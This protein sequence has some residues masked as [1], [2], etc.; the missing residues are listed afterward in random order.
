[1]QQLFFA[2]EVRSTKEKSKPAPLW[3]RI[4]LNGT[5]ARL[6]T[7]H[8][9]APN[10]LVK[11]D[12]EWIIK[13]KKEWSFF[14]RETERIRERCQDLNLRNLTAK[15]IVSIVTGTPPDQISFTEFAREFII[16][17]KREGLS[18]SSAKSYYDALGHLERF[19]GKSQ[20]MFKDLDQ[21]TLQEWYNSLG[22]GKHT[23][24]PK[25]YP[26][27]IGKIWD[28][29]I[30][31]YASTMHLPP[32]PRTL[33]RKPRVSQSKNPTEKALTP[34]QMHDFLFCDPVCNTP[35]RA[36]SRI[37]AHATAV[38]SFCLGGVNMKDLY[39]MPA[40]ALTE[41]EQVFAGLYGDPLW[42]LGKWG[43][44]INKFA[45]YEPKKG[46]FDMVLPVYTLTYQRA[47]T[48]TKRAD[49][50]LMKVHVPLQ[51]FE[52]FQLLRK[53]A[54]DGKLFN[55]SA[56]YKDREEIA[57]YIGRSLRKIS[58]YHGL[59]TITPYVL[60]YTFASIATNYLHIPQEDLAF[61][62]NHAS[63]HRIT[64]NYIQKDYRRADKTLKDVAKFVFTYKGAGEEGEKD[65]EEYSL[66]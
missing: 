18:D 55:L 36:K 6:K 39:D 42:S 27:L 41:T 53:G 15:D 60:R 64:G 32:Y 8:F 33:L 66:L 56:H 14:L 28:S 29:A 59:P 10:D 16:Q 51:A 20:I 7:N 49:G 11:E 61:T 44:D 24:I 3:I 63:A 1:M 25:L 46:S 47:K 38:L 9:I 43:I 54:E 45:T 4:A 30:Q 2:P 40:T 22:E 19:L 31:F 26:Q 58:A 34:Q 37:L 52:A 35:N 5:K 48:K 23:R 50:A 62:M 17:R 13:P 12:G 21:A 65:S 57:N